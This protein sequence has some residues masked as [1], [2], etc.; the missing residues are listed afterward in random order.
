[1]EKLYEVPLYKR[2]GIKEGT[3]VK[4]INEP[5]YYIK[6]LNGIASKIIFRKKLNSAVD[7][8]H[9]F[10]NSK[11]ELSVELPALTNYIKESGVIWV[12]WPMNNPNFVSDLNEKL[13]CELGE[14]YGLMRG[15]SFE[16]DDYWLAM[17]FTK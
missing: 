16:M 9:L 11:K 15:F 1:M 12:S 5:D 3:E 14:R 2:L 7:V 13:V 4:L 6:L 8:I 10:T 17:N